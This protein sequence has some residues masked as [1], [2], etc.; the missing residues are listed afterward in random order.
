[1]AGCGGA[2]EAE[3]DVEADT[4]EGEPFGVVEGDSVAVYTLRNA[5]GV[6]ARVTNYGGIILALLIPDRQGRLED[7][8]LGF[9]SLRGYL[10][11][12]PAYFG[13]IIGRYGNR[14]AGGRFTLDGETY[15][16][17]RND[18][19][20]HLHGGVKGFDKVVWDA[21]SF[22]GD[23]ESGLVF[24]YTSPSAEEGY[25]G[26]LEATV[27]YTLTDDN[28]LIFDYHAVTD[29]PT[30]VNLTQHSYFNLA[31]H[32]A[33]DIL[34]HVVTI[35]AERFTPVDSTLIPTGELRPV[36]G[37]PFD[38]TEPTPIGARI[39]EETEQLRFGLG[40][41][42]NFVLR[43]EGPAE[44]PVLAAR[45]TEPTSGRVMEILTTEPGLQFY[46]GNFL[47]GTL[48]GKGG[49]VY[50]HRTGFAMETQH[51]PDSPN[52]P[53]FPS[54]ILRPGEEYTSRTIYRFTTTDPQTTDAR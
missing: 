31:G 46:S 35:D 3:R 13:A 27:T 37:T 40:Y 6:E 29:Q 17:A 28:E 14:I 38:F 2:P 15:Q 23:G 7:V 36:E 48:T 24:R 22:G 1:M 12:N 10:G 18:G 5:D 42:H 20:N 26:T 19:P 33:G 41:D 51:F 34:D 54:T 11:G 52:Q 44:E 21:E 8:V 50:A 45:V 4:P 32:G 9:D 16:L 30:P 39:E 43:R 25:P 53:D 49:V 47:D